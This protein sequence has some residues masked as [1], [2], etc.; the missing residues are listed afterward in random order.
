[1]QLQSRKQTRSRWRAA[2]V[3][4]LF[5]AA[6]VAQVAGFDDKLKAPRVTT[7][8]DLRGEAQSFG[9]KVARLR[10]V[11]PAG[12]ATNQGLSAERF[13]LAW[14]IQRAIDQA[15][16]LGDLSSIGLESTGDGAYRIDLARN[17]QW[18]KLDELLSG[19]VPQLNWAAATPQLVARGFRDEDVATLQ[20]YVSQHDAAAD[21]R[22]QSLPVV[23]G[24]S[25]FV[26]K[27]DKL[28]RPVTDDMVLSYLYQRESIEARVRREWTEGL[29]R[30]IDAQRGRVL[31]SFFTEMGGVAVWAPSD[32]KAGIADILASMRRPDFEQLV[33]KEAQGATP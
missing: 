4:G 15:Q 31:V 26:R 12:L 13:D 21:A 22:K 29:L 6:S 19:L 8:A 11:S 24:F 16:P 7:A 10:E 27:L 30:S 28:K 5:A 2:A 17:P 32:Q 3:L 18:S 20:A 1:M 9:E 14:K 25:R 23:I 33:Q